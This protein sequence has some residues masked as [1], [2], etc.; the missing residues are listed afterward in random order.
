MLLNG[1][2]LGTNRLSEAKQGALTWQLPFE[3]GV[4]EALGLRNGQTE[5]AFTLKTAGRAQRI[6][7]L[8]DVK[9]MRADGRD[10]CH[11]EF[12]VVDAQGVRVPDATQEVKFTIE[13]PAKLLGVENGDLN[14]S[15]TG[16]DAM[17]NAY[18]GRGLAIVQST[19][20]SGKV[21]LTVRADGLKEAS[22]EIETRP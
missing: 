12:R 22:L 5:S 4:L 18:H 20:D 14:S 6:E 11:V 3:P 7:L 9:E 1:R 21:R 19:H 8:P 2:M 13:G 16:K 15:S 17:R 10:I